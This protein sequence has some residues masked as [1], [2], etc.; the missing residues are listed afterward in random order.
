MRYFVMALSIAC[1]DLGKEENEENENDNISENV[2]SRLVSM[3]NTHQ[4]S[5]DYNEHGYSDNE[6][7]QPE[8]DIDCYFYFI[9]DP[10]ALD[11]DCEICDVYGFLVLDRRE[12]IC[13]S[14]NPDD[15]LWAMLFSGIEEYYS[16]GFGLNFETEKIF[17]LNGTTWLES[18]HTCDW[19][20]A[21][22]YLTCYRF[23]SMPSDVWVEEPFTAYT[24]EHF[25]TL[26]WE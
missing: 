23:D 5:R 13:E 17:K 7:P 20:D 22:D 14:S 19:S 8:E 4:R 26:S 18:A 11:I 10:D 9:N 12:G 16:G 24:D 1:L 6:F 21:D 3:N 15:E 2:N 25:F